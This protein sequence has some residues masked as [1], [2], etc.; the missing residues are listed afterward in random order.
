MSLV[1]IIS[2]YRGYEAETLPLS[3]LWNMV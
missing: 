2:S 3:S 1:G